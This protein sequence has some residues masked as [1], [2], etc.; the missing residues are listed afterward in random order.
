MNNTQKS[1]GIR[2]SWCWNRGCCG[3]ISIVILAFVSFYGLYF[4]MRGP[5]PIDPQLIAHRGGPVYQPENTLAAFQHAIDVGADWLEFD[6]QRS[7]DGVLVV[8]H[9]ETV[10]RTTDGSGKIMAL[11]FEQIQALDAGSGERVPTFAEVITLAQTTGVG[12]MP[13]AKS[14]HLY[15][16]IEAQMVAALE[17]GGMVDQAVVQ[18]FDSRSLVEVHRANPELDICPL[19]G[20][21]Q[22][23]LNEVEPGE[24]ELVCPMAEMVLIN[25]WMIRQ[26]HQQGKN[27]YVWFGIIENPLVMRLLLVMGADGL[28]VDDPLVLAEILTGYGSP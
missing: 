23:R 6:V 1:A 15:P 17:G 26:A 11:T 13:E 3:C 22:L 14:P 28:M 8:I 27:V 9:D 10:D 12:L 21:W 19:Y 25:P 24:A 16:G 18:S 2:K 4:L 7:R 5:L 20:L